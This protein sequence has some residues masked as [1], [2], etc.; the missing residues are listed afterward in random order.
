MRAYHLLV[1]DQG[2]AEPRRVDFIAESPD[3]AFRVARNETAGT[4]CELWD[5][6]KLLARMTKSGA[7]L[8][9]LHPTPSA[10]DRDPASAR[11]GVV[12]TAAV[13]EANLRRA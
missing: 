12:S 10:D 6:D 3:H 2:S 7:E 8:W 11:G 1:A 5:G 4:S 13:A 9:Q